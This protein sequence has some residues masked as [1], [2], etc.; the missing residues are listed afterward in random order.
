[1]DTAILEDIGLTGAEI[2]V[3]LT[4]LELGTS[5]AGDVVKKSGLQ[6]AVVHRAFHSLSEKGIITYVL[7]G[8]IKNYQPIE[9]KHLLEFIDE[10]KARIKKLLPELEAKRA[11]AKKKPQAAIFHG[12]RGIKE[13]IR[14]IID[15][16]AKEFL[17]Y[18]GA[19]K[20]D[21][22]MGTHFWDRFQ[23]RKAERGLT[24]RL[25]FH[26]S[27]KE[28]GDK[29]NK[30]Y[31]QV[32]V[33]YTKEGF[34]ELTETMICGNRVGIIIWLDQPYGFLIGEELAAKSYKRFFEMLWNRK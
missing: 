4:L 20:S 5:T 1:M 24:S 32:K 25:L 17:T 6:N 30:N 18:G 23:E 10:K 21:E 12:V 31:P 13:L 16:N 19:K 9:P 11:L 2:K 29:V 34:E 26:L 22:V 27:L 3:F 7:E 8:R 33:R 15:T 28:W 14:M